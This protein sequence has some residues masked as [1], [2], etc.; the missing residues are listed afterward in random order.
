MK[1]LDMHIRTFGTCM[2]RYYEK[3]ID[4]R[5]SKIF[6]TF[7]KGAVSQKIVFAISKMILGQEWFL[8]NVK[9][10]RCTENV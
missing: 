2:R 9:D 4:F 3:K 10:L 7:T 8:E 5:V 6:W 1:L